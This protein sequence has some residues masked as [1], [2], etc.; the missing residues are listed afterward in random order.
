M[1]VAVS[2]EES[3]F[4]ERNVALCFAEMDLF[5]KKEL[6]PGLELT[7]HGCDLL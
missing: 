5:E 4:V 1:N 6:G 2:G 3:R 7:G